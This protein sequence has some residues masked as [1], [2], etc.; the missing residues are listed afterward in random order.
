MPSR[1]SG[2]FKSK[3]APC[4]EQ[5]TP[6]TVRVNPRTWSSNILLRKLRFL[7]GS[8]DPSGASTAKVPDAILLIS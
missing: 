4:G 8:A 5:A 6:V 7:D 2:L 3:F 1:N